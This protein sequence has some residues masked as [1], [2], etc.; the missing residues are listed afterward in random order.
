MHTPR[1]CVMSWSSAVI[2]ICILMRILRREKYLSSLAGKL[3][4]VLETHKYTFD[5]YV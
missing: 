1:P 3:K 2:I 5:A 4:P